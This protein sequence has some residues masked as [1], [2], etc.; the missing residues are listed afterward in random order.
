LANPVAAPII[1]ASEFVAGVNQQSEHRLLHW[2][3]SPM[4][5]VFVLWST[6]RP[7]KIQFFGT[8]ASFGVDH[9]SSIAIWANDA[10][11]K[12]DPE[13]IEVQPDKGPV[14]TIV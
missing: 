7:S 11:E 3:R 5:R 12:V 8:T 14:S 2:S 13:E 6:V 9:L 4:H 1:G 10:S